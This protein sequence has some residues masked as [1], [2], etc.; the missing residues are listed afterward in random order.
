MR[1]IRWASFAVVALA[2]GPLHAEAEASAFSKPP[3]AE[4]D[5]GEMRGG[6]LLPNGLDVAITVQ[7]QTIVNGAVLL[8]TKFVADTGPAS[9]TVEPG[10]AAANGSVSVDNK[11]RGVQVSFSSADMDVRHLAGQ[12]YGSVI[13]NRANDVSID[14]AS[15]LTIEVRNATPMNVGSTMFRIEALALD[16]ASR[17]IR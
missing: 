6:F 17:L 8:R 12:A 2:A 3:V 15:I 1:S 14:S 13:A 11:G 9:L 10:S 7:S 4:A 16:S 5:L